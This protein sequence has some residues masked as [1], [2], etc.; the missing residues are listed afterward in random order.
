MKCLNDHVP[1]P[2][3]LFRQALCWRQCVQTAG[4]LGFKGQN[5]KYEYLKIARS[6]AGSAK[7][8]QC[9]GA[10]LKGDKIT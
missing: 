6:V 2:E 10:N 1:Y 7:Y 4:T 3:V 9:S 8:K 5:D